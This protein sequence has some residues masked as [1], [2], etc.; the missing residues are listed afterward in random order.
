MLDRD[1]LQLALQALSSQNRNLRGTALEYLDNVLPDDMRR[2]LWRHLGLAMPSAR[3]S[4]VRRSV[5]PDAAPSAG[6][7]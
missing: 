3:G 5:T 6:D 7:C 1:A 2:K 4:D